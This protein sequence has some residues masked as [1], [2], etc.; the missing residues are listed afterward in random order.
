M[1]AL[2]KCLEKTESTF[3][4][5]LT[6]QVV[7]MQRKCLQLTQARQL[8]GNMPCTQCNNGKVMVVWWEP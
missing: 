6:G 5:C 3:F 2:G 4:T 8:L 1:L 7:R